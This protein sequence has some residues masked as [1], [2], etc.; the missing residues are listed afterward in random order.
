M[1]NDLEEYL[2]KKIVVDSNSSWIYIGVLERVTDHC[3][4]LSNVDAQT[5]LILPP[6]RNSMCLKAKVL[7]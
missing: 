2:N 6:Q 4:V 3:I 1:K 5:T 7:V